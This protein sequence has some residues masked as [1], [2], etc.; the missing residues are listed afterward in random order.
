M[1]SSQSRE[2]RRRQK[3][4]VGQKQGANDGSVTHPLH[5]R[6]NINIGEEQVHYVSILE[7]KLKTFCF[8]ARRFKVLIV[9][10]IAMKI[11]M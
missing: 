1:Q 4:E 8:F 2:E 11:E 10:C 5:C 7:T 9:M 3:A 6:K